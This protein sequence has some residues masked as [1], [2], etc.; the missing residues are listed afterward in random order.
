MVL[1]DGIDPDVRHA[2][3]GDPAKSDRTGDV[4]AADIFGD[5]GDEADHRA[6]PHALREKQTGR[7]HD[8]DADDHEQAEPGVAFFCGHHQPP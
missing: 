7:Q 1:A 6:A 3:D 8:D 4:Q 2:P 5:V